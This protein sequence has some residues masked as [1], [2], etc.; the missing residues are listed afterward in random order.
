MASQ[1]ARTRVHSDVFKGANGVIVRLVIL[2]VH[3]VVPTWRA[4]DADLYYRL[5][6]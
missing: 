6:V 4:G 2:F 3:S 5:V 1:W